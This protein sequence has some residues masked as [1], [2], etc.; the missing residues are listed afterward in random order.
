M[1]GAKEEQQVHQPEASHPATPRCSWWFWEPEAQC[2]CICLSKMAVSYRVIPIVRG[3]VVRELCVGAIPGKD[4]RKAKGSLSYAHKNKE[5]G[6]SPHRPGLAHEAS[7]WSRVHM[8]WESHHWCLQ[9][10]E[11]LGSAL[12]GLS[13]WPHI[14]PA[15]LGTA[16]LP[17]TKTQRAVE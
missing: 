2:P 16:S 6:K 5:E 14:C 9:Q 10:D 15:P 7:S 3:C 12:V 4:Q 17:E 8:L 1:S 13:T 11:G